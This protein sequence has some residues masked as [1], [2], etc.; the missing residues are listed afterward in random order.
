MQQ[1]SPE[2]PRLEE[3][4]RLS[5]EA[6]APHI[7]DEAKRFA[8][9]VAEGRFY[10]ACVGQFKRGKSTLL[11]AL[12]D[13]PVLP[14][15]VVP[16]TAIVTVL[17]YGHRRT[18]R[19]RFA[20]GG[21]ESIDPDGLSAYVTEEENPENEKGVTAVEVF[22]PSRLL[23]S[24]MCLVDTPGLGSVFVGNTA[25][26]QA[27]VPH[28]D[29]ALVVLGAD[30][31]ISGDE[32]R[33]VEE[34]AAQVRDLIFVLNKADRL[35][36][37]ERAEAVRFTERV[38]AERLHRPVER[39]YE[40]S[41]SERLTGT[42]P[43]RDWDSLLNKALDTLAHRSGAG[44][45]R[46]AEER[47]IR[48]LS[49]RLRHEI[50]EARGALVRPLAESERRIEDL[51]RT[52]AE[53]ERS[54]SDLHYLFQGE[55]ERLG[56]TFVDRRDRFLGQALR[57]AR[58]DLNRLLREERTHHR[59][60]R[61]VFRGRAQE[62]ARAIARRWVDRW[63]AAEQPIAEEM[64]R[65]AA[66]RFVDLAN[67]FLTRLTE[68]GEPALASLPTSV[69]PEAGF[70]TRSRLYYTELMRLTSPSPRRW[71]LYRFSRAERFVRSVEKEVAEYLERLL[72]ANAMRVQSD[73]EDRVLESRRRL[74]AEIRS[75][76]K[77]VY[78]SAE[79]AL[80][81][82]SAR[83]AAGSEAVRQEIVRFDGLRGRLASL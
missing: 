76:L 51:R 60:S 54:M 53:A 38:L 64:Y 66:N 47:G 27:F 46:A 5:E 35:P 4:A 73:F 56:R 14:T 40:V 23:A 7:A 62:L 57:G 82:A 74:E 24:G 72:S 1:L 20:E 22:L 36:E 67:G 6:G 81:R 45:V 25:V 18:A 10:V 28:I 41:A 59:T 69:S 2:A 44:L 43:S 58:A 30:P 12:V 9:R 70:R 63:L 48:L 29:A 19:L 21:W 17:R 33:L 75:S 77:E 42:G 34:V 31:P 78:R 65:E 3:L 15:G 79:R 8:E 26:T 55:Q 52:A 16:V 32:L 80:E 39:I 11:N 61:R 68:S 13:D 71:L 37:G 49:E 83:K 50:D